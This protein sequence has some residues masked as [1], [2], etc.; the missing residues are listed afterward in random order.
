M[1]KGQ[2]GKPIMVLM[3]V[4][5][6]SMTGIIV[7]W[8]LIEKPTLQTSLEGRASFVSHILA[9]YMSGL[10]TVEQG[11]I[12]KDL[13]GSFDIEIGTYPWSKRTYTSIKPLSNYYIRV[14][15]YDKSGDKKKDSGQIPFVGDLSVNCDGSGIFKA[16]KCMVFSNVSF[17][18]LLKEP[19]R[20]VEL[21]TTYAFTITPVSVTNEFIA[22]YNEYRDTIEKSV[23]D[24]KHNLTAHYD[25][26]GALIAGLIS[27]ESKWDQ[28]AVSHC[29][30]AGLMQMVPE[31]A[32][33]APYSLKVPDYTPFVECS[34][35]VCK[36]KVSS[37]NACDTSKCDYDNDERFDPEKAIEAGVHLLYDN[38]LKCGGV[39]GG[40]RMYNSGKCYEEANPG[41]VSKVMSYA[42]EWR[43]YV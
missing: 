39:E 9:S 35:D 14:T 24:P 20:P 18:A 27:Q 34:M 29:G 4:V 25:R 11:R 33:K 19:N 6:V 36:T 3:T 16:T 17:I 42:E 2:L 23:S 5:I 10:S 7:V 26:P 30:A 37:C 15:A 38:I 12:E 41:F 8:E 31:T 21:L 43:K 40:L 32:R 22:K 1:L 28:F 13:N